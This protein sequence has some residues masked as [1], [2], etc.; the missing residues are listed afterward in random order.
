MKIIRIV[1]PLILITLASCSDQILEESQDP[2]SETESGWITTN[3]LNAQL[4]VENAIK[5]RYQGFTVTI[6]QVLVWINPNMATEW[7]EASEVAIFRWNQQLE[8]IKFGLTTNRS[9][10]DIE[11]LYD[12]QETE[13]AFSSSVPLDGNILTSSPSSQFPSNGQPVRKLW[14]NPDFNQCSSGQTTDI[15][16]AGVQHILGINIGFVN[17]NNTNE[18]IEV[19]GVPDNP[20]SIFA[21]N[22]AC[23]RNRDFSAQDIQAIKVLYG[24]DEY[25]PGDWNGSSTNRDDVAF[26]I[27]NRINI[28]IDLDG[29]IDISFTYGT[30][31]LEDQYLVGDW[32]GDGRDDI[33]IRR[34]NL[35]AMGFDLNGSAEFSFRYGFGNGE[36]DYLSGDFNGDGVDDI[37]V[38]R[39]NQIIVTYDFN[40]GGPLTVF[41]YG[42]GNSEDDYLTGDWNGNGTDGI[43]I[44]RGRLIAYSNDLNGTAEGSFNFGGGDDD[45]QYFTGDFDGDGQ[46]DIASVNNGTFS[47]STNLNT[48]PEITVNLGTG[49][50]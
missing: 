2:S 19:P 40:S 47:A 17:I 4:E 32:N 5:T 7:R 20:N 23:D 48:S 12:S 42:L 13:A 38:R 35:I 43:A 45:F 27:G 36:D 22:R 39:G 26:R 44:R 34:G 6:P 37:A 31:N 21:F 25:L 28:D 14:I 46:D 8:K 30:G 3:G 15:R 41:R 33:A 29:D 24:A 1:F 11:I 9:A 49:L 50:K 18:G 16:V 10:A